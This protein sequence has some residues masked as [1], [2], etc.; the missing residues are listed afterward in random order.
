MTLKM[1]TVLVSSSVT[2]MY[3][4]E[5]VGGVALKT[6]FHSMYS[7]QQSIV[8]TCRLIAMKR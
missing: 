4:I 2:F 6:P 1:N 3:P 5:I 7:I 8:A